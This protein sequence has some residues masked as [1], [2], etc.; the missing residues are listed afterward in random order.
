MDQFFDREREL[1]WL[2]G[3]YRR[4]GAQL[5]VVYGR[6]RI[7]KTELLR[8]FAAGKRAVYFYCERMSVR[9]PG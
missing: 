3:L 8:R 9:E 7:G 6:R 5:V 1:E 2:E 4:P